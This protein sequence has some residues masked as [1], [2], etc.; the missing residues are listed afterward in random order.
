MQLTPSSCNKNNI[1]IL[2]LAYAIKIHNWSARQQQHHQQSEAETNHR[3][4]L[5]EA[6]LDDVGHRLGL[7][8]G[9]QIRTT[10]TG[11]NQS[12][13]SNASLPWR[14]RRPG[15]ANEATLFAGRDPQF[16]GN[17]EC[18]LIHERQARRRTPH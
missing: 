5:Y 17:C 1:L 9:A 4:A 11:T 13:Y 8:T 15:T 18:S 6:G 10:I 14:D 12:V 16:H 7:T 3:S 2:L